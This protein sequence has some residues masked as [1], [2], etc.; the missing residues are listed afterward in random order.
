MVYSFA[1]IGATL[2]VKVEDVF[3]QNRRLWVVLHEKGGE[4]QAM[5][6]HHN[7]EHAQ[8]AYIDGAGLVGDPTR[9]RYL[10]GLGLPRVPYR[11]R[12]TP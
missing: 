9:T 12:L 11:V 6:C 8:A 4:D 3:M 7:L 10:C 1:R 5:P 2:G